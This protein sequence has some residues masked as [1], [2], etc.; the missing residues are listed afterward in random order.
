MHH[1]AY[2]RSAALLDRTI[3]AEGLYAEIAGYNDLD[4]VIEE[5]ALYR[6]LVF[7]GEDKRAGKV[8]EQILDIE[9]VWPCVSGLAAWNDFL[10]RKR[11]LN[12]LHEKQK[13]L[14]NILSDMESVAANIAAT[15][16]VTSRK[17]IYAIS[18]EAATPG[19]AVF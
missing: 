18:Q 9:Y 15:G 13:Y 11:T 2:A 19:Q 14:Q 3:T 17:S 4:R 16:A 6:F 10:M 8:L 1:A 7:R 12:E 5:Y